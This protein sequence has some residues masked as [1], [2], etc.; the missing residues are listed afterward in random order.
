MTMLLFMFMMMACVTQSEIVYQ[1]VVVR[2]DRHLQGVIEGS[3]LSRS[4]LCNRHAEEMRVQVD[5][6][7]TRYEFITSGGEELVHE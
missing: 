3:R 4:S 6:K 2:S 1:R 5:A 7:S